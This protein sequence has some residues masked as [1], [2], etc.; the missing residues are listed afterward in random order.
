[1]KM[2]SEILLFF[3][4]LLFPKNCGGCN[5][6]GEILCIKCLLTL[7]KNPDNFDKNTN[8]A[9]DYRSGVLKKLI[10]NIKYKNNKRLAEALGEQLALYVQEE[11]DSLKKLYGGEF[12]VIC[13][14]NRKKGFRVFNHAYIF[15]KEVSTKNNLEI[16][17]CL[18]YTRKTENQARLKNKK[19]REKNIENS[20]AVKEKYFIKI[21]GK[22]IILIDDIVTTGAT[23]KEARRALSTAGPKNIFTFTLAH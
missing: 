19:M 2:I 12:I 16:I 13:V 21:S 15:A 18:Y 22:N 20:M 11:L 5:K 7:E 4:E 17:D 6:S 14:P 9:F 8:S 10:W 1:M 3:E 23:I